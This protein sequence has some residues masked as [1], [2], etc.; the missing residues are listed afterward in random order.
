M[1]LDYEF[2]RLYKTLESTITQMLTVHANDE[3][4]KS[5]DQSTLMLKQYTDLI[6]QQSQQISVYQQ[7]EK[8]Y[9]DEH[10][11]YQNKIAELERSLKDVHEQYTSL[12][13][14]FEKGI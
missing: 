12:K 14:L 13:L 1:I 2:A 8:Q 3:Q 9:F 5:L 4:T 10:H 7:K 6:Q 11:S